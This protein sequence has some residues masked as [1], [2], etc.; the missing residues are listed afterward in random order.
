MKPTD[1]LVFK[2]FGE[3]VLVIMFMQPAG[4]FR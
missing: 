4:L 1:F 3:K 2:K